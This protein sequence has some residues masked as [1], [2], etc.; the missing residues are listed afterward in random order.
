MQQN[1]EM[2]EGWISSQ[3]VNLVL[4]KKG[5]KPECL[6]EEKWNESV[7]YLD[8]KAF[9]NGIIRQYADINSSVPI[10]KGDILVVWDG[11][12]CGLVGKAPV[13]GAIGSTLMH[14]SQNL[15]NSDFLYYFLQSNYE[16]INSNP[17]GTGIPH[18]DPDR[19]W[20]LEVPVPLFQNN[21]ALFQH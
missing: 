6:A 20:N 17:R 2:P 10:S 3:L 7:P 9:E 14:I 16:R 18:V 1:C 19:F 5:K 8:I 21:S 12:R 11:A 13:D 15:L 4:R